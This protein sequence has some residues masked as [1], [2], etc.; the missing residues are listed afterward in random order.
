MFSVRLVVLPDAQK[1]RQ[2]YQQALFSRVRCREGSTQRSRRSSELF[3]AL[4]VHAP[5]AAM[6][7][8]Y[9]DVPLRL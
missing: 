1:R 6:A 8:L 5:G 7:S 2:A 3:K 4:A 9:A